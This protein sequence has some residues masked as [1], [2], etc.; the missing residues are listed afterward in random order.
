MGGWGMNVRTRRLQVSRLPTLIVCLVLTPL[1][2]AQVTPSVVVLL[3]APNPVVQGQSVTFTAGVIATAP[4]VATGTITISDQCP[5]SNSPTYLGSIA[6]TSGTLTISSFPCLGENQ[7]V[8]AYGG[9]STYAS[10]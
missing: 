4:A 3:S 5:G 2:R 8:A 1:V 6:L 9:D 7:I 10:G